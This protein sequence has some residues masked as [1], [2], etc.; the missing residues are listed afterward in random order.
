MSDTKDIIKATAAVFDAM[1]DKRRQISKLK[2]EL[3]SLRTT[4]ASLIMRASKKS[5]ELIE[6]FAGNIAHKSAST[7][8]WYYLAKNGDIARL[9]N[10]NQ[11]MVLELIRRSTGNEKEFDRIISVCADIGLEFEI[12]DET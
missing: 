10:T 8:N 3:S 12:K 5:D 2:A 1:N 6:P 7:Y 9:I 11:R 4:N